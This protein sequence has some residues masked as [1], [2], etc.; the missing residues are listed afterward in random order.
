MKKQ[1]ITIGFS[2]ACLFISLLGCVEQAQMYS[3]TFET[4]GGSEIVSQSVRENGKVIKPIS[5]PTKR[6]YTFDS[7]YK[8]SECVNEWEFASD[9]VVSNLT[10]YAKWVATR[11]IVTFESQGGS[12]PPVENRSVTYDQVYGTLPEVTRNDYVF[13]GWWTEED[14]NGTKVLSTTVVSLTTDQVLYAAWF[15]PIAIRE[16]G[17][18]NGLVFYDKLSYS[19]GWRYLEASTSDIELS[20]SNHNHIFGFYRKEPDN[21]PV[22]VGTLPGIG[23]GQANTTALVNAMESRAYTSH[24]PANTTTS[25]HYAAKLCDQY[26]QGGYDDWF[27]PSKDEIKLLYQNLHLY[28]LGGF[29]EVSQYWSSTEAD[30]YDVWEQ[31]FC[32]GKQ[33]LKSRGNTNYV[34]PI[35]SF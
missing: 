20:E 9:V 6:G 26:E 17:P 12:T 18:A 34:R 29:N 14:G 15:G 10:L 19:D 23:S 32:R 2:I 4:D 35:R 3:I 1:S 5:N 25:E 30:Y 21:T 22:V 13:E 28:D 7:W 27:L 24:I 31:W 16:V 11:Y 8:E 33:F